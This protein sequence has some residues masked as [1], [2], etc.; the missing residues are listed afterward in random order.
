[1]DFFEPEWLLRI[2]CAILTGIMIGY[3]R[4]SRYKEAGIRTHAI[5]AMAS[6]VLM[7][8]S[9]HAFVDA[10][11]NDPARIAAQVVSGVGFLGTGLIFVQRGAIQGLTTA[12]GIWA[13]SAIG[14]CFGAGMY[15]IGFFSGLLMY[16]LQLA[17]QKMFIINPPRNI[18]KI[19][20]HL[21]K[22]ASVKEMNDII[23]GL[24]YSHTENRIR[25]DGRDGWY[26]TAELISH[27]APDLNLL[28]KK[29]EE[30]PKILGIEFD[31]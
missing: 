6:C 31:S 2:I 16:V 11:R 10:A 25:G 23:I 17:M 19:T 26:V 9:R 12:A 21:S 18:V 24:G 27:K 7:I 20:V 14:L 5:V 30:Q 28:R 3:E 13:T 1:M 4:H 8:V 15:T 29:F 22:D